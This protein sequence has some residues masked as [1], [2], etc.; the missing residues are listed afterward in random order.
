M[1]IW[2]KCHIEKLFFCNIIVVLVMMLLLA[3]CGGQSSRQ[4]RDKSSISGT[5]VS[6]SVV[7]DSAVSAEA[8]SVSEGAVS[9]SAVLE[10]KTSEGP[11]YEKTLFRKIKE[12]PYANESH[13]FE[14]DKLEG[15]YQYS[16]TGEEEKYYKTGW[17]SCPDVVWVDNECILYFCDYDDSK[18]PN[19]FY[20]APLAGGKG[21]NQILL[22][23]KVLLAE[24]GELSYFVAKRGD[25]VY[26]AKN[27]KLCR[28][29]IRTKKLEKLEMGG[30]KY[31]QVLCDANGQPCIQNDKAYFQASDKNIYE[32]D[33]KQ[34][35]AR[36]IGEKLHK[37]YYAYTLQI[38][39]DGQ[40]MY[41][42]SEQMVDDD[43]GDEII[44]VSL[45]TGEKNVL[46][47]DNELLQL[48][49]KYGSKEFNEDKEFFGGSVIRWKDRLCFVLTCH[50]DSEDSSLLYEEEH[51]V[52]LCQAED[53]SGI[54]F[55]KQMADFEQKQIK[56]F[57][58]WDVDDAWK[59]LNGSLVMILGENQFV[60]E[61]IEGEQDYDETT[62]TTD[63]EETETRLLL[64]DAKTG[65][66]KLIEEGMAEYGLLRASGYELYEA[67]DRS[68]F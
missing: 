35:R 19:Q 10:Q 55:E 20:Y 22:K 16:L 14:G 41:Y 65:Q 2:K 31:V 8:V 9:G 6:G 34:C 49:K 29:N 66:A 62:G 11:A 7:S 47:S 64:Y 39:L 17:L 15:I 51:L 56:P 21:K 13:I 33:L 52:F 61:Y 45:D 24:A 36:R 26:F 27:E 50:H 40:Y 60:V 38:A 46:I 57:Y 32:Y 3:G 59:V 54:I 48:I 37:D 68:H 1:F 30:A 44:K 63:D 58:G 23:Q 43:Y 67:Y 53:G 25:N 5:A 12:Q 42:A 18:T 4:G 28:I